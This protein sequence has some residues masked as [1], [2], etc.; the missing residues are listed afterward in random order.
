MGLYITPGRTACKGQWLYVY[1]FYILQKYTNIT[2]WNYLMIQCMCNVSCFVVEWSI[3]SLPV[4]D[5]KFSKLWKL[6]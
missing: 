1:I 3:I 6:L 4:N 5:Y 2:K